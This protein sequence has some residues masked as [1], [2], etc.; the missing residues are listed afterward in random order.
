M[1]FYWTKATDLFLNLTVSEAFQNNFV[2]NS[3]HGLMNQSEEEI[4]HFILAMIS[5]ALKLKK[6]R[7]NKLQRY[8]IIEFIKLLFLYQTDSTEKSPPESLR[9]KP[10]EMHYEIWFFTWYA[11]II[12]CAIQAKWGIQL[13]VP[14][15][16]IWC[17]WLKNHKIFL[18]DISFFLHKSSLSQFL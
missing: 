10:N 8:L 14:F 1:C 4:M 9:W 11:G 2:E 18:F 16:T 13:K 12:P 3:E 15:V 17:L 5:W 7:W 6:K